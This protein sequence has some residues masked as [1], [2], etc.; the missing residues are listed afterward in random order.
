MHHRSGRLPTI[1]EPQRAKSASRSQ[2]D[3]HVLEH[4]LL[5]Y[6]RRGQS[7]WTTEERGPITF[8]RG[9]VFIQVAGEQDG[10]AIRIIDQRKTHPE[11]GFVGS[12]VALVAE[13]GEFGVLCLHSAPR[14]QVELRDKAVAV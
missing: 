13:T 12:T 9:L 3:S 14:L 10:I 11:G 1:R 5:P 6:P 7:L 2:V 4:Y 8:F